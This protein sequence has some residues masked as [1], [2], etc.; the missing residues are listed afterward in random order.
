MPGSNARALEKAKTL[1]VDVIILDL[2]D[3][4]APDG[5]NEA[6]TMVCDAVAAG[7]FG[8]REVVI[9][10]NGQDTQWGQEDLR[11]A[12]AAKPDAILAPKVNSAA[13]V[14]SLCAL[15][16]E[17]AQSEPPFLWAMI[18]TPISILNIR[19]IAA[20][21]GEA[22]LSTFVMGTND[23]AKEMRITPTSDRM[24]FLY[25]L[26]ATVTAARAFDVSVIDGVFNDTK[27]EGSFAAECAQG[28]DIGFDGKTLIHPAQIAT[29]NSV[30]SPT[31]TAIS[32]AQAIVSAF[33]DP[34]NKGRG[35]IKV[36][37]KMTELL[38]LE[39]ARRVLAI[40]EAIEFF[41]TQAAVSSNA[42]RA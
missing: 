10:I 15:M 26:S 30:F 42:A 24:A 19:E 36:D 23:L 20:I 28:R 33:E 1:S 11:A 4:V 34:S 40:A 12:V 32:R 38:H 14:T 2:E 16:N 31:Q 3:S 7:G 39:E 25:A 18:E 6:R 27:D 17:V 37:G 9:R 41:A 35:V 21:A 8:E 29:C 22:R 13:D 5:K